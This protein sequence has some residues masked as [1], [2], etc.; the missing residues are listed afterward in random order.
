MFNVPKES[1]ETKEQK[2]GKASR[3][4]ITPK[5]NGTLRL[6]AETYPDVLK[7][8]EN[9]VFFAKKTFPI[10]SAHIGRIQAW[11]IINRLCG[12]VGLSGS[13]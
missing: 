6:Y 8:R 3:I 13:H 10:G 1:F 12:G 5:V 7:N 11:K 4:S 2:T 9:F